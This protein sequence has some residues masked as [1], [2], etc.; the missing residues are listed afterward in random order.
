MTTRAGIRARPVPQDKPL[1]IVLNEEALDAEDT[2]READIGGEHA[3]KVRC[4]LFPPGP[5]PCEYLARLVH[6]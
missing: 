2:T 6:N 4:L 5:V 1:N 3:E